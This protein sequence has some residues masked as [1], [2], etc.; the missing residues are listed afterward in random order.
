MDAYTR[1]MNRLLFVVTAGLALTSGLACTLPG[2]PE[3][4]RELSETGM[5]EPEGPQS[6]ETGAPMAD[7]ENFDTIEKLIA[8]QKMQAALDALT[9]VL[10]GL[11]E[12]AATASWTRA[13][14][15]ATQLRTALS[16]YET[17]VSFL[18]TE[19]WP[20]A[21]RARLILDLFYAQTLVRYRQAYGWDIEQRETVIGTDQVDLSAWTGTQIA[22]EIQVAF[23]R[24]WA[25]R[26]TWGDGSL[27]TLAEYV[28][29]NDYPARLRG[30]LRDT[31]SYL[32]AQTLVDSGLWSAKEMNG[33]ERLDFPSL[34]E[35]SGDPE[36]SHPLVR[37]AAVLGDLER[38]HRDEARP[39][40][41]F[42]A[43]RQR[44]EH[45]RQHADQ[46]SRQAAMIEALETALAELGRR[47]PWWSMGMA[48][49]ADLERSRNR[50]GNLVRAHAAARAA[51][52]SHPGSLGS[53]RAASI[54]ASIEA[55]AFQL[56][57]MAVDGLGRRSV[58]VE[59]KNLETLH[60]RAIGIDLE[61]SLA[62]K[63]GPWQG[64]NQARIARL[65]ASES[66]AARWT[67]DLED[68][69]DFEMHRSDTVPPIDTHGLYA[70]VAS[71]RGDFNPDR[72]HIQVLLMQLSELVLTS[73]VRADG[74]LDVQVLDGESGAPRVGATVSMLTW[75]GNQPAR[76][77]HQVTTDDS[78]AAI[79]PLPVRDAYTLLA[80]DDGQFVL[81]RTAYGRG[82]RHGH[83]R[84]EPA[85]L[86][87]TDRAVY[88]PGQD[89]LFKTVTYA[90]DPED[91]TES[92]GEADAHRPRRFAVQPQAAI[93]V[94]LYDA[95]GEVVETR[96]LTTNEFGT[97]SGQFSLPSGRLL[98]AWRLGAT[99]NGHAGIQV[100]AYKRPTFEVEIADPEA[101]PRLGEPAVVDASARYYFGLPVTE[102][103]A[104]WRVVREPDFP[105]WR[106]FEPAAAGGTW[107]SR[108]WPRPSAPETV[109]TGEGTLDA[110]GRLRIR[111]PTDA[112]PTDHVVDG[113][114]RY[115]FR[116]EVDITSSGG[117]TRHARRSFAV[118]DVAV[119]A[120]I[121]SPAG[122]FVDDAPV[123]LT[124][125]RRDL[126]GQPRAG[127]GRWR[128]VTIETPAETL[129][130][131]EVPLPAPPAVE[132]TPEGAP[133][134]TEHLTPGDLRRPRWQSE[135]DPWRRI[136]TWD[137]GREVRSGTV[138][139][140]PDGMA[141]ID[142]GRLDAGLHRLVY[143]TRDRFEGVFETRHDFV[144]AGGEDT[145]TRQ[146]SDETPIPLPALLL[147]EHDRVTA[148][149]TAR[150][151]VA[152]GRPGQRLTLEV[153]RGQHVVTRRILTGGRGPT[154]VEVPVGKDDR[155]G[156]AVR[157][158]TLADYQLIAL[159]R[160]VQ[161]PYVD[162]DLD[163]GF[164]T[165]RDRLRAGDEVTWRV[166]VKGEEGALAAGAAE[167]L[168]SMYDR[169][170]DLFARH[171]PPKLTAVYPRWP[172]P[173]PITSVLGRANLIWRRAPRSA[174]RPAV[175]MLA[176]DRLRFFDGWPIGGPGR[177]GGPPGQPLMRMRSGAM[178]SSAMP[179]ETA[180]EA[181]VATADAAVA[182]ETA[183]VAQAAPADGGSDPGDGGPGDGG[184]PPPGADPLRSDFAETAFWLPQLLTDEDGG[185]SFSFTAPDSVT[186][187]TFWIE[188][189]T[190]DL[191]GGSA[192]REVTTT[193][194]LLVR[195]QLPRFLRT[196]DRARFV[197]VVDNTG[198]RT[199]RGSLDFDIVDPV[200]EAS[201]AEA[202][203][204]DVGGLRGTPFEVA[205][206]SSIDVDVAVAAP[207]GI[208]DF[209]VRA[210]A[211]AGDLADGELR[212]L[213]L[214]PS[215]MHLSTSRFA[216]VGP[217]ASRTLRF[218]A[219]GE[220][221]PTR[222]NQQLVIS[223][224]GQLLMSVLESVPSLI[225]DPYPN[226]SCLVERY[227]AAG[228]LDRLF[229]RHPDL[230]A[231]AERLA[232]ARD[233]RNP[234]GRFTPFDD[235][236]PNR[237]MALIETPWLVASRGG[238]DSPWGL[239][240]VLDP[241]VARAVRDRALA[242]LVQNQRTDG[243]FSWFPGG[244]ASPTV[245]IQVLWGFAKA[246]ELGV[247][248][249]PEDVVQRAWRY[250][251]G[252]WLNDLRRTAR[253]DCCHESAAHVAYV[254]SAYDDAGR[255]TAGV[256]T[257]DDRELI[258]D[259]A[260]RRWKQTSP[261][262]K[263]YLSLAL[264]RAGR[265]DD[266]NLVLD[267]VLDSAR[268][269]PDLGTYWQPEPRAWLFYNDDVVG[270]AMVLRALTEL[271][272]DDD[273]RHG[274]IQWLMLNKK[275]NQWRSTR[276]TAEVL[277]SVVH[278]L[279][280][281]GP[282]LAPDAARVAVGDLERRFAFT[283]SS[284]LEGDNQL[285]VPGPEVAPSMA[286][287]EVA[288]EG[289]R[290]VF[291][292]ATWHYST[293]TP[294]ASA[295]GDLFTIERRYFRRQATDDGFA[296]TPIEEGTVLEVGDQVEV[297][298]EITAGSPAEFVHARDPRP[299]GLEPED[300]RSGY[301]F[302][303]GVGWYEQVADSGA[304]LFFERLPAGTVTTR[305]RLR[306]N[307]AGRFRAA[308]AVIQSVYAPS[309]TGHSAGGTLTIEPDTEP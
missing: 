189:L 258:L 288:N 54:L 292:R 208:E 66:P 176:G 108:Y 238:A 257:E 61:A 67:L 31:V 299:A 241:E 138:S 213:P 234:E 19:P 89:V 276:A 236:D 309:F 115:R 172:R 289:A 161:V 127:D 41:A 210:L 193:R 182:D 49:L 37:M 15:M 198:D 252:S 284:Y 242:D 274:L 181:S 260:F 205:P 69:G 20:D 188:A 166:E 201:R 109:A 261:L 136:E 229:E 175:S 70:L 144:V 112:G 216:A 254:L 117:E 233:A 113:S 239:L 118:G 211:R 3:V 163:I 173:R 250:V 139:H 237:R 282:L 116:L 1:P 119:D 87:Y 73:R 74:R 130:P 44:L 36:A 53:K 100:E 202:F 47:Y 75:R 88:R 168:A 177:F 105:P 244:P 145:P 304:D 55:P 222:E 17:A 30:T 263:V 24:A 91:G 60:L 18:R 157:L 56:G 135:G 156:L 141:T 147:V 133:D 129:L 240:R 281:D 167:I 178:K 149:E 40:A 245:T 86:I 102:G 226:M 2:G 160:Q 159:D 120:R 286:T 123:T 51:A 212:P 45:L 81:G 48:T 76:R 110:E 32:W 187:W 231:A 158:R 42:E 65:L 154:V 215:R 279:E 132:D 85:T 293:D 223:V 131:A 268:T 221:D 125:A 72:G 267:S 185:V 25:R 255:M 162:R 184:M 152:S 10:D 306:A 46:E 296:L 5:P 235:E 153:M 57:A 121:D 298:L 151:L 97:A 39:E 190:R 196:G 68:P 29:Q 264:A 287:I 305:Y 192:S 179:Q 219:L 122:F 4:T 195:P 259:R 272:P 82:Q 273:R 27:G 262:V 249:V 171:A 107:L 58:G 209:A 247:D 84:R 224:D 285:V 11:R 103:R 78:G 77:A 200:T 295:D 308:P 8:E 248:D 21:P 204:L 217:D 93:E 6:R 12:T 126:D 294:P 111:F 197:V 297:Q 128:L 50:P 220:G 137:D 62:Q 243:A 155:G 80:E 214:L 106:G 92:D 83:G 271:R 52:E 227:V 186:A 148:G 174:D 291:A 251:A 90:P 266:S 63:G 59:H 164:T 283:P 203:G 256:F 280:H 270:H 22:D 246:I 28:D 278:S 23:A 300:Q 265:L 302:D 225:D 26:E 38:W 206:G 140:G 165:F 303:R 104:S 169:S 218:E 14:V 16:G 150:L 207:E 183:A 134:P 275:L 199:L 95:N 79:L 64:F 143:T 253:E 194:E 301:R 34:L 33:V 9:P 124:V 290:A 146:A 71:D 277:Y 228:A 142:L 96:S 269:D 232:A 35:G 101:P 99:W 170:L 307:V 230:A 7:T 180:M 13:L 43:F 114:L 94:A 191:R 98:G